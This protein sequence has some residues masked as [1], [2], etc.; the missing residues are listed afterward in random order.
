MCIRDR[1]DIE[2]CFEQSN[3]LVVI[4]DQDCAVQTCDAVG[5][6]ISANGQTQFVV[7]ADDGIP[8]L[9][10]PSVSNNMGTSNWVL[11][12][13]NGNIMMVTS[14]NNFNFE[15]S[16]EGVI[17]IV[18]VSTDETAQGLQSGS[19]LS[20]LTGCFSISNPITVTRQINCGQVVCDVDGGSILTPDNTTGITVC[21]VDDIDDIVEISLSGNSGSS[22]WL[23]VDPNGTLLSIQNT[24]VFA[25]S[26]TH[27]TL[28]TICSV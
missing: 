21:T 24:N 3:T 28:P 13:M 25:V 5:G 8:D 7:C 2:G 12:D 11:T 4:K 18:H 27:L 19:N 9:I 15:G 26:Y 1:N 6:T 14:N 10:I 22:I 17:Q 20:E 16:G 23:V